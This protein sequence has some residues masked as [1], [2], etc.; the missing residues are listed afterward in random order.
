M[1]VPGFDARVVST[2]SLREQVLEEGWRAA[3]E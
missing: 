2:G 3:D 1:I